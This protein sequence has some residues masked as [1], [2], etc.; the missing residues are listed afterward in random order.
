MAFQ[1]PI[2]ISQRPLAFVDCLIDTVAQMT[3]E[4]LI[5]AIFQFG[6]LAVFLHQNVVLQAIGD[7]VDLQGHLVDTLEKFGLMNGFHL[8][9][10]NDRIGRVTVLIV[11]QESFIQLAGRRRQHPLMLLNFILIKA[12]FIDHQAFIRLTQRSVHIKLGVMAGDTTNHHLAALGQ[13]DQLVLLACQ[14]TGQGDLCIQF[15]GQAPFFVLQLLQ[16]GFQRTV[17]L[18]QVH[19]LLIKLLMLTG[20]QLS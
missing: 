5:K 1:L 3:H 4:S 9:V 7:I 2:K 16:I 14:F 19:K 11:A 13:F 8:R 17:F 15:L 20:I 12:L 18:F 6:Q 10:V